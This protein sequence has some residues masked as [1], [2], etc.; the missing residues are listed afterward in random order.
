MQLGCENEVVV[1][2]MVV[3]VMVVVVEMMEHQRDPFPIQCTLYTLKCTPAQ[4]YGPGLTV[5][6]H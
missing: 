5:Y 6:K 2:V 3:M 4:T 1:M